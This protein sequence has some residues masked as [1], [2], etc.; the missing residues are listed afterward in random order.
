MRE[1]ILSDDEVLD[2]LKRSN[3]KNALLNGRSARWPTNVVTIYI[4]KPKPVTPTNQPYVELVADAI[5]EINRRLPL[6]LRLVE[7]MDANIWV[8]FGTAFVPE[9]K[10]NYQDYAANV[11]CIVGK[12]DEITC[13]D[14]GTIDSAVWINIGHGNHVASECDCTVNVETVIH[15]FGHALG[16]GKHFKGFGIDMAISEAFWDVLATLYAYVPGQPFA[17]MKAQRAGPGQQ[18]G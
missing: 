8:K 5:Q 6:T 18:Q 9:G 12:G 13:S 17:E 7:R 3:M 2:E 11:S 10:T 14:D 4:H 15:E 1:I 16:L